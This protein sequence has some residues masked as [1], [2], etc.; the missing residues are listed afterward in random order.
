MGNNSACPKPA[1]KAQPSPGGFIFSSLG[2][3]LRGRHQRASR[4]LLLLSRSQPSLALLALRSGFR[5][6]LCGLRAE[7]S[8]LL[9]SHVAVLLLPAAKD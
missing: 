4:H 1:A 7:L 5:Q 3:G 9:Q 6:L 2:P 8:C